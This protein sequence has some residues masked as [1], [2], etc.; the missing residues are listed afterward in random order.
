VETL[1]RHAHFRAGRTLLGVTL[2]TSLTF[3]ALNQAV[4]AIFRRPG[5]YVSIAV[6]VLTLVTS[7]MS[8]IPAALHTIGGYLPTH[9][10][11]LALRGVIIGSDIAVTGVV[12]LTVWL[13]VG[14][15]ATVIF[16]E[17]RRVLSGTQLRL[18]S[19]LSPAT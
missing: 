15:L 1:R 9:A 17:Q 13:V 11:I 2:L 12:Q 5:R 6:L 7:L 18:G 10:A 4:T 19:V 16:T 8:T 14:T 3:I